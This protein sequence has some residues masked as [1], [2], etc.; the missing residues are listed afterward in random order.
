MK[1]KDASMKSQN[2]EE[3]PEPTAPPSRSCSPPIRLEVATVDIVNQ[4]KR[5]INE[6]ENKGLKV[7]TKMQELT[8]NSDLSSSHFRV[9][10]KER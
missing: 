5:K 7:N 1:E 4:M 9:S 10:K 8:S 6:I 2:E 3:I